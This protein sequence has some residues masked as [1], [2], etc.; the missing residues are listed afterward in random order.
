MTKTLRL[1]ALCCLC[2]Q[3]GFAAQWQTP[4]SIADSAENLVRQALRGVDGL[5]VTAT[6]VDS[7]IKL[8]V[9][10]QPLS[11][12]ASSA[13]RGGNGTV[14][15]SCTGPTPWKLYVP[16]RSSHRV[17]VLVAKHNVARGQLITE[18]DVAIER[19]ASESLPYEYLTDTSEAIGLKAK[20]TLSAGMILGPAALATRMLVRRSGLVALVV[21]TSGI[22]VKSEGVALSDARLHQRVRVRTPTGRV[23]EGI[24]EAQDR[25]RMG[26]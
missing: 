20:R 17:E 1:I 16:V 21:K 25:V 26:F 22:M 24:V 8:P 2:A 3:T 15:V 5:T 19:R 14:Q 23:V 9:C 10:D 18:Q 7:R 6:S 12:R 11:A 13:L 4:Q